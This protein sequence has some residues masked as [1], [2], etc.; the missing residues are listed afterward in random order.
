MKGFRRIVKLRKE[1]VE[2]VIKDWFERHKNIH[3]F[4]DNQLKKLIPQLVKY[5]HKYFPQ[6]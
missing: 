5:Y 3:K 6:D 2:K 1:P 4:S